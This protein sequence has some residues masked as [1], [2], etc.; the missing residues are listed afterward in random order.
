LSLQKYRKASQ[1]PKNK[2]SEE[3]EMFKARDQKAIL[4]VENITT[5]KAHQNHI[6]L[7]LVHACRPQ[8]QK[9]RD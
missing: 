5:L 1:C 3:L 7:W 9:T 4:S 2:S 8:K 6:L